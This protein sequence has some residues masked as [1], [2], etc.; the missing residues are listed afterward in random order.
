MENKN[1]YI[2]LDVGTD[3]VGYAVTDEEYKLLKHKG[4]PIWGVHLFDGANLCDERRAFRTSRRRLGR[5][6][7]RVRLI[8]EIFANEISKVDPNFFIRIKESALFPEDTTH[9]AHL[10]CD[11][12]F[13]D[14][15]YHKLYP[16]IHHLIIDLIR[17]DA[18][19]D[20]RL[21]YLACAWLV[22]HRGHFLNELSKENLQDILDI[23]TVYREFIDYFP[24]EKPWNCSDLNRFGDVLKSKLGCSKKYKELCL[25][26]YGT[27]SAPKNSPSD[28]F[29][30][31][32]ETMVKLLC[33]SKVAPSKLFNN[34][35][36]AEAE[37][38][39]LSKDDDTLALI[40]ASLGDDA[41]L[42]R[43][44]KALYDWGVLGDLLQ[45]KQYISEAKV[46][47]YKQHQNDLASLKYFVKT[48]TKDY[49]RI[50]RQ[51]ESKDNYEAYVK[52]SSTQEDFC[53]LIKNVLKNVKP[54]KKDASVFKEL[55]ERAEGNLLCPK[56][57][58]SD[59]C[60]V[61]YQ[62]YWV[63]LNAILNNAKKYLS[64][65][66]ISEDGISNAEKILSV[67]EFK[68]PY[69]VGPLNAK[70]NFAWIKRKEGKIYPW[71]FEDMVDLEAS[72]QAFIDRMTNSCTYLPD[73]DVLPKNSLC[74]QSFELLNEINSLSVNGKKIPVE[75][76][77]KLY[78]ELFT[79][80]KK[81]TKKAIKEFL[82]ANN[83]YTLDELDTLSGIDDTVKSS[84]SSLRDF[85][86]LLAS[87][88]LTEADAERIIA[89]RTYTESKLRFTAWVN[90]EF[91]F[92]SETDRKYIGN[93]KYKDFGRLSR[94]L[95][96][97]TY[98][99]ES[100]TETGEACTIL[101]RMWNESVTLMQV[102]SDNYTYAKHI[103][104][105][106][107]EYYAAK[108][109][110]LD[111]RLD[112]MYISNAVKRPILR[113]LDVMRDIVKA[114]GGAPKKIFIEMAR[115]GKPE[116]KGKRTTSR[117]EQIK[118][119]Y[120]K[121]DSEDVRLL[122]QELEAMG[123]SAENRLQSDRL[124]LYY[125]Q[126]GRC[127]YTNEPI[128]INMLSEKNK[129]Y[130][131][132]HI[133]PQSK[134]KD[135]SV[136]NNKVLVLSTANEAKGNAYPVS[137]EIRAKMGGFWKLLLDQSLITEEKYKRLMRHTPFTEE[138][139]WGFINRQLVETRQS[140]K[141]LAT[142]L[143]DL[144][145]NSEIVYV[146]AGLVSDFRQEF[147]LLKA[148]LVNDLHHAKDAY[149][150]V[151]VGN[152]YNERFTKK[153]FLEN[154]DKYNLKIGTLFGNPVKLSD[155]RTVWQGGKA[156]DFVKNTVK[157]KNAIHLTRYAF[158]RKGGLFDQQPVAP[159]NDLVPLKEGLD[160]QKYGGYNKATASFFLLVKYRS[161]NKSDLIMIAVDL[162]CTDK[163]INDLAFAT[164]YCKKEVE[165]ITGQLVL[166]IC[167]P[168]GLRKIKIGSVFNLDR[169]FTLY[170]TGKSSGGKK[171]GFSLFSPLIMGYEWE[172]YVKRLE[173]F[174]EK[175]KE[176]PRMIYSEEHDQISQAANLRLFDFIVSKFE[177]DLYQK[178]P[179]NPAVLL[180][181]G[182]NKFKK[183]DVFEQASCLIQMLLIF[184]R[185]GKGDLKALGG[186]VS[187]G[188]L[189]LSSSLSNWKKNYS[190]V[191]IIDQSASGLFGHESENLFDLL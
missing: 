163:V 148:R 7:Q 72:E 67:F 132:D 100:G 3:S 82:L 190:D 131:I 73:A 117:L 19:H 15:D 107:S 121:C 10:F 145:P 99:T 165:A 167:F 70:S 41:E 169:S 111:E 116:G 153:W 112:D 9:G 123:D 179:A 61:P 69:F 161:E 51:A 185:T 95:L 101:E 156:L 33:G 97:E 191:R 127:M 182:R 181:N 103:D 130:D 180:R 35:D 59:N 183:L 189:T 30:Y 129:M 172:K 68:I 43:R 137:A 158:C 133:Y 66:N 79:S 141:A 150:N 50:F 140:T 78:N 177:N 1:Y 151:V 146:K 184:S 53:K 57:V 152:V 174:C 21:V 170:L 92:L 175:K 113:T 17:N 162:L 128:D 12:E 142:I 125:T 94:R 126:L 168:L 34:A 38:F 14:R 42:V 114:S 47:T 81:V 86:T 26:L 2:G 110:T 87:G 40:F 63:E 139:Q 60:V 65:L 48:Y 58:N 122:E 71:N 80:R 187:A 159:K 49:F 120:Q 5:C 102:L 90:K 173:K 109:Q 64:F 23:N 44:I 124:F 39:D 85:K 176:N 25:L 138:E 27:P 160:I 144:Y 45:G 16:T 115:G 118:E 11:K 6:Q 149:L 36:Y 28:D 20:V 186:S 24:E 134:V 154:S 178:R 55:L 54:S 147:D 108:A 136:L 75:V 62:V 188:A 119:L 4:E 106:R 166:E 98:G 91:P 84:L 83:F 171:I 56:Q 52:G 164:E 76:K 89:R 93:L 105:A 143:S 13:S 31:D 8:Q 74:Y 135:D 104:A 32:R 46:E 88:A 157:N 37:S 18:P 22:A 96:C 29:P 77:Q 155:G